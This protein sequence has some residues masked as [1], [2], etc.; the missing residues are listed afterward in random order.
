M[1]SKLLTK[2]IN[3]MI[4]KEKPPRITSGRFR[5]PLLP[6]IMFYLIVVEV[7]LFLDELYSD[8][9]I[10]YITVLIFFDFNSD[11]EIIIL[12]ITIAILFK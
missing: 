10:V 7:S 11:I 3:I 1:L 4:Y 2:R 6:S 9:A 12:P 5:V 8:V